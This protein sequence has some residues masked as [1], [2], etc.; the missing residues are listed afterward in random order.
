MAGLPLLDTNPILRHALDD[1]PDHSPRSHALFARVE[2]G[3][4]RLRL[5]DAVVFEAAFTLERFY[6]VPR[7][8][9]RTT[10][11]DIIQLPGLVLPGKQAYRQMFDL[12]VSQPK[13]SFADCYHVVFVQ[14][15]NLPAIVTFDQD[16][17]RVPG[18]TRREP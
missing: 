11:L 16:F 3:Q 5:T 9:I 8:A 17:D 6:K 14:R 18:L 2:Q 15:H 4:E 1:H 10:L 13:L 12:W 7:V